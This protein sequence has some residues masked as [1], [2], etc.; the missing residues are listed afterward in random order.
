MQTTQIEFEIPKHILSK[1]QALPQG[2]LVQ[3]A[4]E[5]L[6]FETNMD[7]MTSFA[8][9]GPYN[10]IIRPCFYTWYVSNI[11]YKHIYGER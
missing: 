2:R 10:P 1:Y 5:N 4:E 9:R 7:K 6:V 8:V 11:I 3:I